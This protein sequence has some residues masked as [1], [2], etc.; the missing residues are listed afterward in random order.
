MPT[1]GIYSPEREEV[2]KNAKDSHRGLETSYFILYNL[3]RTTINIKKWKCKHTDI[4]GE[5]EHI[6]QEMIV[7]FFFLLL[8]ERFSRRSIREQQCLYIEKK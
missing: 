5:S 6:A 3:A 8:H 2:K 4:K 1:N 7:F